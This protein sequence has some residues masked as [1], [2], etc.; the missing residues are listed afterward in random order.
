V[1]PEGHPF[2]GV[3]A[4]G[5]LGD[6]LRRSNRLS[7]ERTVSITQ[8][9]EGLQLAHQGVTL[10]SGTTSELVLVI[11][12]DL[13]PDNIFLV[14][15]ALGELVKILDFGIAKIRNDTSEHSQ[16][17]NMFIGTYHYASPEQL[18]VRKDLDGRADIYSLGIILYEMLSGTN[19]LAWV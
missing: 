1:T 19:R 6:L 17:T 11:H 2:Y 14:P 9:C 3:S 8:V 4:R 12:R 13:K 15:T 18:R 10:D 16:L 5:S 7:V